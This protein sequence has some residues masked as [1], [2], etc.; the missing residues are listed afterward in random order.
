MICENQYFK[1]GIPML[2]TSN[3]IGEKKIF[4]N[5][6]KIIWVLKDSISLR[7]ADFYAN[8]EQIIELNVG[9][10][11]LINSFSPFELIEAE[12]NTKYLVFD[13]K[14]KY[15]KEL[16]IDFEEKIYYLSVL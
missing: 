12:E 15:L 8:S 2:I 14:K 13:F 1:F 6:F 16:D 5:S 7:T 10:L 11:F 3:S 4:N 9:Q